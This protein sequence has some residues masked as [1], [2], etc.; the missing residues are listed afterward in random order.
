[1]DTAANV[2]ATLVEQQREAAASWTPL[3]RGIV[4]AV[5]YAD[6]FD[7]PLTHDELF[8]RVVGVAVDRQ[9]FLRCLR[10][11]DGDVLR[12]TG[13]YICL[14]GREEILALRTRRARRTAPTWRAAHR[15]ARWLRYVPFMQSVAV[16]GS[17]AV[18]NVG[19]TGDVDLFCITSRNRLWISR[20]FLVPLSKATRSTFFGCYLCP[21]YLLDEASLLVA[22]QNLFTAHEVRQAVPLWGSDVHARFLRANRWAARMLP[23][24][25]ACTGSVGSQPRPLVRRL[26]EQI[27]RG[28]VGDFFNRCAHSLF[29]YGYKLRARR[30]GWSWRTLAPAYQIGRYTVPEG[31]YS[32]VVAD[33]FRRRLRAVTGD[34]ISE[35]DVEALFPPS[36]SSQAVY[37]WKGLFFA[38]YG[39][40][41]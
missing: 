23:N 40:E 24:W 34:R 9:E 21:N 28:R 41:A 22:D 11:L 16:S 19:R 29:V 18:G 20:L 13:R 37:D 26:L 14:R 33:V 4:L 30:R 17:L 5:V 10:R 8:S 2:E 36:A 7:F 32:R 38:E 27:L 6:V 15:F 35:K 25:K 12:N 39:F 3:E 31:G 1:M